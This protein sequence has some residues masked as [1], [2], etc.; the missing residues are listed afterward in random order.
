[1]PKKDQ[2]TVCNVYNDAKGDDKENLRENYD[3][4]KQR[5][6]ESLDMK[7]ADKIAARSDESVKSITF[8]LQAVLPLPHAGDAQIFYLR[9]LAVYNFTIYETDSKNGLC[10][11]WDESEGKRSANEIGSIML[12]YIKSLPDHITKITSFSDTC[13]GQNRNQYISAAMLAA[14]QA[15]HVTCIDLKYMESGHSYLEADSMHST[16]ESAKRYQKIYTTREWEILI[17]GARKNPKPYTVQRLMHDDFFDL[18]KMS[19]HVIRN[20]TKNS[21]GEQVNWLKVKWMRFEKSRPF[22]IQ[23]KYDLSSDTFKE[24]HVQNKRGRR[25]S[26]DSLIMEMAYTDRMPIAVAKKEDLMKLV[27]TRVIP[28]DYEEWYSDLPSSARTRDNLSEP[29]ADEI[30]DDD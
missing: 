13:A 4:H 17:A 24:L 1:M 9:K 12:H 11:L 21:D 8:D 5:E 23:Y 27:K 26:M 14:V 25:P 30:D 19:G 15:S 18:K 6:K 22:V 7:E 2:C 3:Q 29:S 16:I 28:P 20:R 10:Y